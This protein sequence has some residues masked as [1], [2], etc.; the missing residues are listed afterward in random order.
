MLLA[1]L[2]QGT[3]QGTMARHRPARRAAA[4]DAA[5]TPTE[6][7]MNAQSPL[8]KLK[9]FGQSIWLDYIERSILEDGTLKRMIAQD[10]VAGMTSNPAIFEKA[11]VESPDY[12]PA[13]AEMV[14]R[15][16]SREEIY[17][18]LAIYDVKRAADLFAPVYQETRCNDGYVSLE[19]SPLL[20]HDTQR[21]IDEARRLWR[22][23]ERPNVM[24]KVPATRA[25]LPAVRELISDGI[26]VNVTLLFSVD[27]YDEVA[28]Q[29]LQGLEKRRARGEPVDHVR[30]VA[31][32]FL[33]R[34]DTKVDARLD[35]IA[36]GNGSKAE[37]ARRLRG[38]A[39]I[40]SAG[41]A[42]R[43]FQAHHGNERWRKLADD[44]AAPQRLLW[45]STSTKDPSYSDVKYVEALIGPDT[46]NTVPLA[47]LTA[48]RDHGDPAPRLERTAA[49]SGEVLETLRDAGVDLAAIDDALEQEGVR[50][51]VEPFEKLLQTLDPV[52]N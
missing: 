52:R 45:A 42:Y 1:Y 28:E 24:I 37:L 31:S 29:Y 47:T 10:G 30:S 38:Q 5:V 27:R 3:E 35:A 7:D 34:I 15:D 16:A 4:A 17:E 6:A 8:M 25:G 43:R 19:V 12:R 9:Q 48:Y 51:F 32:F 2:L 39:A 22:L 33:S 26:N 46:V 14:R 20:A 11:I 21:T 18:R 44:G 13:I 49:E 41:S 23:L 40:A 36:N 50:K